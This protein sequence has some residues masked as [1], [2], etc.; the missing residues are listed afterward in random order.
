[1]LARVKGERS[2]TADGSA[3]LYNHYGNQYGISSKKKKLGILQP[4]DHY[5]FLWYATEGCYTLS[6]AED[7]NSKLSSGMQ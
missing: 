2:S 3:N 4:E 1:M 5:T 7:L 6:Q